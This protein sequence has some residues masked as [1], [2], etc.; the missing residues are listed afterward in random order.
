MAGAL[1]AGRYCWLSPWDREPRTLEGDIGTTKTFP[2]GA[3]LTS[4][5]CCVPEPRDSSTGTAG[6]EELQSW[7]HQCHMS[8]AGVATRSRPKPIINIAVNPTDNVK[9]WL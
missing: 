8:S 1:R 4:L 2:A 7:C 5:S 6:V 9:T 3:V